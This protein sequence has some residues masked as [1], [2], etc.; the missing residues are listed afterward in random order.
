[1]QYLALRRPNPLGRNSVL[2]PKSNLIAGNPRLS[3]PEPQPQPG[4]KQVCLGGSRS[5]QLSYRGRI[6]GYGSWCGFARSPATSLLL[7]PGGFEGLQ[8]VEEGANF[9]HLPVPQQ[10]DE[11]Q[12]LFDRHAGVFA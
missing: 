5:I 12:G 1:V 4:T 3:D 2:L 8:I 6:E 9:N 7:K 10:I 11:T